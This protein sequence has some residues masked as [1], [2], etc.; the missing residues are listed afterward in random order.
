MK[1]VGVIQR[2]TPVHE[3]HGFRFLRHL[4]EMTVAMMAGMIA[5]S[6]VFVAASGLTID[7]ALRRHAVVF[8]VVQALGMTIAMIGW[9]RHRGHSWTACCEMVAAMVAPAIPLISLRALGMISGEVC[10]LYCASTL[11]AMILVM[12]YRRR[13]YGGAVR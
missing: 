4:V 6:A 12:V 11:G 3:A 5:S 13:D 7:Q 9:M 1:G 2:G 10:S 8:V